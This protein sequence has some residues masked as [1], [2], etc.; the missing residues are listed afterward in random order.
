MG[1][2]TNQIRK[3]YYAALLTAFYIAL[4]AFIL[5]TDAGPASPNL[6]DVQSAYMMQTLRSV[7]DD[8]T[9]SQRAAF[10]MFFAAFGSA[11]QPRPLTDAFSEG[12]DAVLRRL[13]AWAFWNAEIGAAQEA[14][15]SA[16]MVFRK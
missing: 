8:A 1:Y 10:A 11:L 9:V 13:P 5:L 3:S 12:L 14:R 16:D 15:A 4:Q 7:N 2:F 6:R